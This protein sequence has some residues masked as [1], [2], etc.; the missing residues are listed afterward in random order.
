MDETHARYVRMGH[1]AFLGSH[2]VN[3]VSAL[4][5]DLMRRTVFRDLNALYPDRIVNKTNGVTFRRWLHQANPRLR[6]LLVEAVGGKVLDDPDALEGL[7]G[8]AGDA[9][10][11]DRFAAQRRLAKTAL[12]DLIHERL[13][14]SVDPAALFDVHIKRI[15]EYK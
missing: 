5:T 6:D 14:I 3:G 11:Q 13:E 8:L 9:G 7:A 2:R 12:T 1:L 15:H 4:H 10:L